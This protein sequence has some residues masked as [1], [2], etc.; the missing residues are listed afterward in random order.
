MVTLRGV[1]VALAAIALSTTAVG[2]A[3]AQDFS[4]NRPECIAPAAPGGGF[5]LTCRIAANSFEATGMPERPMSVTF[6]PGGIGAVAYQHM[7]TA[8]SDD[9]DVIVAFSGGSLLNIAQGKFGA[10]LDETDARWLATAGADFG[11]IVVSAQTRNSVTSA[12]ICSGVASVPSAYS[13]RPSTSCWPRSRR[14]P[15]AWSSV[16]VAPSAARTG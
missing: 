9:T 15:P 1:S 11:V 14:I 13:T 10:G 8:R 3:V 7:N 12:A 4:P 5:D 2:S 6:M 16:P